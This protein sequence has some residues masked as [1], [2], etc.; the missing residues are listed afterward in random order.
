MLLPHVYRIAKYDPADRDEHGHYV[1]PLAP[2]SD[3]GVTEEGYVATVAAFAAESGITSLSIR[4]PEIAGFVNFGLE[5]PIDGHGLAGLFPANLTGYHDGAL[6]P[7]QTGLD[8]VRAMLRD[9]GAWCRLEVEDRFFVHVGYD[10][11]LYVGS[12]DACPGALATAAERGLFAEPCGTSPWA[13]EV[14]VD[15]TR[16]PADRSFWAEVVSLVTER[17]RVLLE[18]RYLGNASRW[19][20]VGAE[21][22]ESLQAQLAPRSC[23]AVWPDLASDVEDELT[24]FPSDDLIEIIWQ[25][26]DGS[27]TS[28]ITDNL[29]P[30]TLAGLLKDAHAARVLSCIEEQRHPLLAGVLPDPDGTLRARWTY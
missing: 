2:V 17:G 11:Y 14:D 9:S 29:D 28:R 6:V 18:E 22:I 8:L 7:I 5:P 1:G 27:L 23:V 20:R 3:H 25:R 15:R 21:G 4:E 10:Q 24:R 13:F 26:H 30:P 16:R 12:T 19:H